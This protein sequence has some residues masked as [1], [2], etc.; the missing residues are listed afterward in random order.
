[1]TTPISERHAWLRTAKIGDLV[2]TD[3]SAGPVRKITSIYDGANTDSGYL[4]SADGGEPCACCGRDW[5]P[6]YPID[7]GW[8]RPVKS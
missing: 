5:M 3:F 4:V 6:I 7:G 2:T 1:M 8:F